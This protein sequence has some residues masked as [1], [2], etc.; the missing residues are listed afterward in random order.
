MYLRSLSLDTEDENVEGAS[1]SVVVPVVKHKTPNEAL[2]G[3]RSML[4]RTWRQTDPI[5]CLY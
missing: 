2:K 1:W 4:L 3:C 5:Q